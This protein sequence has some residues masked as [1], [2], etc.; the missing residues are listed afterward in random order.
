MAKK[1]LGLIQTGGTIASSGDEQRGLGDE[2]VIARLLGEE[3]DQYDIVHARP[4]HILSENA[5]PEHWQKLARTVFDILE[6]GVDGVV[7]THGTDTMVYSAAALTFMVQNPPVPVILTG[8]MMPGGQDQP[9]DGRDNLIWSARTALHP[10]APPEV[11]ILFAGD[12]TTISAYYVGED[13]FWPELKAE[14]TVKQLLIRG[15]RARKVNAREDDRDYP[16]ARYAAFQSVHTDLLGAV[17]LDERMIFNYED[18]LADGVYRTQRPPLAFKPHLDSRVLCLRVY[19]GLDPAL[20]TALVEQHGYRGLIL[21]AYADG[22]MPSV[23]DS[24]LEAAIRTVTELGCVVGVTSPTLGQVTMRLYE[25]GERLRAAGAVP[26]SDLS[27]EVAIVKLMWA[28]GNESSPD[29][30]RALMRR[31]LFGEMTALEGV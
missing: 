1:R 21:E 28:L 12:K 16:L 2:D 7:I 25:G 17:T 9:S 14:P 4:Y 29:A 15:T 8:S 18:L 30:V 11:C 27:T 20:L 3:A 22:T 13:E 23:G 5:Q 31:N 10:M 19:P 6:A 26:L 24:S